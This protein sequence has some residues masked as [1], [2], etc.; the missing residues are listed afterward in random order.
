[1][2][3]NL[4]NL[5]DSLNIIS[6]SHISIKL[7]Y[8]ILILG[9]R[10]LDSK[11]TK[12][13]FTCAASSSLPGNLCPKLYDGNLQSYWGTARGQGLQSWV[14]IQFP[15]SLSISQ[16][17]ISQLDGGCFKKMRLSFGTGQPRILSLQKIEHGGR[18]IWDPFPISPPV[19]TTFIKLTATEL[20]NPEN[21]NIWS[22]HMREIRFHVGKGIKTH[23]HT[24]THIKSIKIASQRY[25]YLHPTNCFQCVQRDI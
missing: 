22:Y 14:T 23:T 18:M 6:R 1:M 4:S 7:K 15:D 25:A 2:V 20:Y 9:S 10:I 24:H 21:V 8:S 19:D 17:D 5:I 16:I 12:R 3:P 11:Y 13:T